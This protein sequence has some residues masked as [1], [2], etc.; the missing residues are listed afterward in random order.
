MQE[1]YL[2][3]DVVFK[4]VLLVEEHEQGRLLERGVFGHLFVDSKKT[5]CERAVGMPEL[6]MGYM[7]TLAVM[8]TAW[9]NDLE[10]GTFAVIEADSCIPRR[11]G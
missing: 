10:A 5:V 11:K 6:H 9:S 1:A 7:K 2:Y 8:V 4:Q 3:S